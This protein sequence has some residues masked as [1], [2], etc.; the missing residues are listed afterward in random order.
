MKT[1]IKKMSRAVILSVSIYAAATLNTE[2]GYGQVNSSNSSNQYSSTG[3]GTQGNTGNNQRVT[4]QGNV[5]GQGPV[6]NSQSTNTGSS[7]T[8]GSSS[9]I[10][11]Y[12]QNDGQSN[13]GNNT[14]NTDNT[15]VATESITDTSTTAS[16]QVMGYSDPGMGAMSDYS[17]SCASQRTAYGLFAAAMVGLIVTLSLYV[18][19]RNRHMHHHGTD[20]HGGLGMS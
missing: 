20:H 8:F 9:A 10:N 18:K 4:P 1:A 2:I 14:T 11:T 17:C 15:S 16:T 19:E 5:Y 12:S 13:T 7:T 6:T 3:S